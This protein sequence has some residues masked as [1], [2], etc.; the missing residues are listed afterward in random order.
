MGLVGVVIRGMLVSIV[1]LF[2]GHGQEL[3]YLVCGPC[4]LFQSSSTIKM[5]QWPQH[6]HPTC[7][8]G[9]WISHPTKQSPQRKC[10]KIFDSP[11]VP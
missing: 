3:L 10:G 6:A 4:F 8:M 2:W 9:D 1:V 11:G 7:V 5:D